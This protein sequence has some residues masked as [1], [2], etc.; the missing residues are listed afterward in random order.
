[1][2]GTTVICEN[3]GAVCNSHDGYCKECWKKLPS[4]EDSDDHILDGFGESDWSSFI[5]KN[6]EYYM[7]IFK[8]NEGKKWF[9]SLNWS[10]FLLRYDWLF[11]RRMYKVAI[12][13][14]LITSLVLM[15]LMTLLFT[16]PYLDEIQPLKEPIAAYEQ[17]LEDGGQRIVYNGNES[18]KPEVVIN[19]ERAKYEMSTISTFV[20]LWATLGT[21][22][23]QAVL[24]GLFGN[25]IY[26][27][28]IR[29]HIHEPDAGGASLASL[30]IGLIGAN[31]IEYLLAFLYSAAILA[32]GV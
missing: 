18:Y 9:V 16:V 15:P 22:V 26:K 11:Y 3:C 19:G 6:T 31:L 30:Y 21:F 25:A 5:E 28:H 17:Y 14:Y 13:L 4:N 8:K 7:P 23:L 32:V 2:S 24:M 10:A 27:Q 1:M 29:S 20:R 12:L